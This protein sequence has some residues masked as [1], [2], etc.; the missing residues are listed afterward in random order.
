MQA[1]NKLTLRGT[2]IW[3]ITAI[4]FVYEFMGRV[5][6]GSFQTPIMS[7]VNLTLVEFS[8]VSSTFYQVIYGTMQMPVGFLADRFGLKKSLTLAALLCAAAM[9][10]FSSV[11]STANF[12]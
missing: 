7:D 9:L 3:G 1:D 5:M 8:L 2:W 10:W 12:T 6:L 11:E 4:F